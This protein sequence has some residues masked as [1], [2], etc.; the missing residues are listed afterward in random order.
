MEMDIK[1]RSGVKAR[2]KDFAIYQPDNYISN[3]I[4]ESKIKID[5]NYLNTEFIEKTFGLESRKFADESTQVSDLAVAAAQIILDRNSDRID[6]LIFAAASSDL[7]EPATANIIQHKLGLSCPCMDVKNACNS[8]TTA[9]QVAS[10]YIQ[11]NIASSVLIVNG[12]KLS[13]VIQYDCRDNEHFINCM[14][15]FTLSDGGAAVL[16]SNTDGAEIIY[17][18]FSTIGSAWDICTVAGGGSLN[19]RNPEKYFFESNGKLLREIFAKKVKVFFDSC[20]SDS[21]I[22]FEDIDIIITHQVSSSTSTLLAQELGLDES[23]FINTFSKNGNT[24]AA[25]VLIALDEARKKNLLNTNSL[26]LIF[27]MAAGVSLSFQLIQY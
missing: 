19:F 20:I 11:S 13:E 23:R 14:S 26:V 15:G 9:I 4:I 1:S 21:R 24:A 6:L 10:A 5:S 22:Q 7:I 12:E 27:G 3:E 16:I 2:I 25:T 18:Q 17:Q 8:M